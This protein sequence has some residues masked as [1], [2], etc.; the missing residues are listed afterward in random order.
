M[1]ESVLSIVTYR[2]GYEAAVIALWDECNLTRP[3]NNPRMD[4][5]RMLKV[6]PELFLVA[7]D[8][9]RVVGT[10]MGGYDGHRGWPYY[11]GVSPSY[12]K[13]GL[14]KRLMETLADKLRAMGCPK[15]NIQVRSDNLQALKFYEKLGYKPDQVESIG[16][17]LIPD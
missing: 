17:R 3:W 7:L 15:I 10:V 16:L 2:P 8:D 5:E 14:G 9:N 6:Y 1:N 11:L 13:Q 12:R 4:I